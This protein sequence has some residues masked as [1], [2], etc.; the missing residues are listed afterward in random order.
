MASA[1]LNF[2]NHRAVQSVADERGRSSLPTTALPIVAGASCSRPFTPSKSRNLKSPEPGRANRPGELLFPLHLR[3]FARETLLHPVNP[4]EKFLSLARLRLKAPSS[5]R[6][7]SSPHS[8]LR[9]KT[10]FY[11][12]V[13]T[14]KYH[15]NPGIHPKSQRSHSVPP[16][17]PVWL[18]C[19]D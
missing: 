5:Q 7:P 12:T 10:S 9:E 8:S 14:A 11:S 18:E 17:K 1:I 3:A 15:P 2:H 4:I 13:M 16:C 19:V 6:N